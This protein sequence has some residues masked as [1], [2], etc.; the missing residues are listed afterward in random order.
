V[1]YKYV[2]VPADGD[3]VVAV[4]SV[5]AAG[6]VA[7]SSAWGP[8]ANGKV[9]PNLTSM[10]VATSFFNTNG[11]VSTGSGTSFACPNIAGLLTC[12]WQ[13]FPELHNMEIVDAT[14]QAAHLFNNP[15][16]R[17]GYGIPNMKAAFVNG[18][19]K[20]HTNTTTI[21]QC[22]VSVLFKAKDFSEG[23]YVLERK[24][25]GAAS[26]D[27]VRNIPASAAPYSLKNYTFL[28]TLN[29]SNFGTVA[30]RIK[31]KLGTDTSFYYPNFNVNYTTVCTTTGIAQI[32]VHGIKIAPNPV[33]NYL[34]VQ[35]GTISSGKLIVTIF[36]RDGK[37]V[38][39]STINAAA[40]SKLN[41]S[42]LS[43]GMYSVEIKQ[44]KKK[45]YVGQ[46]VKL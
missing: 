24:M 1:D 40:S 18:L 42:H 39:H 25:P 7:N 32:N 26:F 5:S 21:N 46:L 3:S 38:Y 10:G 44:Q 31:H 45:L 17:Y 23:S 35:A 15:D 43:T 20:V 19:K 33:Q 22:A 30:Y 11:T 6:L 27:S 8:N 13:A 9:K 36:N 29:G 41:L 28:D 12:L 4:G 14:Q 37:L 2:A 16:G 34:F